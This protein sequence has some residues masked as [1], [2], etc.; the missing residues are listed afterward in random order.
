M[1]PAA[2]R[3]WPGD[4]TFGPRVPGQPDLTL[5]FENVMFGVIP[6]L[7]AILLTP[8]SLKQSFRDYGTG[9]VSPVL[10][11]EVLL[12]SGCFATEVAGSDQWTSS[13]SSASYAFLSSAMASAAPLCMLLVLFCGR[14]RGH[15]P[16]LPAVYAAPTALLDIIK[17]RSYILRDM[18]GIAA[19][20]LVSAILKLLYVLFGNVSSILQDK[21][22][23]LR[24]R[25][26]FAWAVS[27][28]RLGFSDLAQMENLPQLEST[29][30]TSVLFATFQLRWARVDKN[31][32]HPLLKVCME[33]LR[34]EFTLILTPRLLFFGFTFA[35][36]FI[37]RHVTWLVEESHAPPDEIG[38]MTAVTAMTFMGIG[39][40][41]GYYREL[42]S[43]VSTYTHGLLVSA[44]FEK[45]LQ[46]DQ[47][48]LEK[49]E[50][51]KLIKSELRAIGE[52]PR[53]LC[54][55]AIGLLELAFGM[56]LLWR[57]VGVWCCAVFI[58]GL[59]IAL[60]TTIM[61][62][63]NAGAN[64]GNQQTQHRIAATSHALAQL[65][66]IK[67]MGLGPS[68]SK[69][70]K[71]LHDADIKSSAF[72]RGLFAAA[73][74][75]ETM[76]ETVTPMLVLIGSISWLAH[77]PFHSPSQ[78]FTVMS[79]VALIT[80]TMIRMMKDIPRVASGIA[81][82]DRIDK[83]LLRRPDALSMEPLQADAT[84]I[85]HLRNWGSSVELK[86]ATLLH[87]TD[88]TPLLQ[89]V[90]IK[91]ASGGVT[92][93]YSSVAVGKSALA[94]VL[95]GEKRLDAGTITIPEGSAGYCDHTQW[96]FEGDIRQNII[97]QHQYIEEWYKRILWACNIGELA[98]EDRA[99]NREGWTQE[100]KCC[101][102]LAR[103]A[104]AKPSLLVMDDPCR[105][106]DNDTAVTVLDRLFGPGGALRLLGVTAVITTSNPLHLTVSDVAYELDG[107][108]NTQ[109]LQRHSHAPAQEPLSD[110]QADKPAAP[111][112]V[113][114]SRETAYDP[115]LYW[116]L[117]ESAGWIVTIF[118]LMFAIWTAASL[119]FSTVYLRLWLAAEPEQRT[120]FVGYSILT[121]VPIAFTAITVSILY[122]KFAPKIAR[123]LHQA[124]LTTAFTAGVTRLAQT[125]SDTLY[126][127]FIQDIPMFTM[128]LPGA[129]FEVAYL[130]IL[131]LCDMMIILSCNEYIINFATMVP[132]AVAFLQDHFLRL[133]DQL[134]TLVQ[135]GEAPVF[136]HFEHTTNGIIHI[137]A[138]RLER[139][140]QHGL[141]KHVDNSLQPHYAV[142]CIRRWLHLVIDVFIAAVAT[143]C[144][145]TALCLAKSR[146][147]T[148]IGLT[149][150][151]LV[152][153]GTVMGRLVDRWIDVQTSFAAL[154]R[155]RQF[156]EQPV[157]PFN[158]RSEIE[159]WQPIT[160]KLSMY[161]VTVG[162]EGS[163][164][165]ADNLRGV[166]LQV[167]DTTKVAILGSPSSGR[168]TLFLAILNMVDYAGTIYLDGNNV[169]H[170]A[171]ELLRSNVITLPRDGVEMPGSIRQ[172]LD[173]WAT[174]QRFFSDS[175]IHSVLGRIGATEMVRSRGGLSADFASAR[176]SR[177]EKQLIF[178]ARAILRKE[179]LDLHLVLV[180]DIT[181]DL[182]QDTADR[183][184]NIIETVFAD[185]SVITVTSRMGV[186]KN[187]HRIIQMSEGRVINMIDRPGPTLQPG[188]DK[189]YPDDDY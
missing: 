44:V 121:M 136:A 100:Q 67:V 98:D 178:L 3:L 27:T 7:I 188:E 142:S 181:H 23:L 122:M 156:T 74:I 110:Y 17:V 13:E 10:Y 168:S 82:F 169:E 89:D 36:P 62:C 164:A 14:V 83:F 37:L 118:S 26:C 150:L 184:H 129:F 18:R 154:N 69:Y 78:A 174:S 59:F 53:Q 173:P 15:W 103:A 151:N 128:T 24:G 2:S 47:D 4:D 123:K 68:V 102:Q 124:L 171:P 39:I 22:T 134:Q 104:Y 16:L 60:I 180:D 99:Q 106:L 141:E 8:Y 30:N 55:V 152:S 72:H 125:D 176:L 130:A 93:I 159:R 127:F 80:H 95:L 76:A 35:Q 109:L 144:V 177:A 117:F 161:S 170:L 34:R 187:M 165:G 87:P 92:M 167:P 32:R 135:K 85:G 185:C 119:R 107:N 28:L 163:P 40:S 61:T 162:F 45:T 19:T 138:M 105:L 6:A 29:L 91:F 52:F 84:E 33:S 11:L 166:S 42:C 38:K 158:K 90:S 9:T 137:R 186:L 148:A 64:T 63:S 143:F 88:L 126:N 183:I 182:D 131:A 70:L 5:L 1:S 43:R 101:V 133:Y 73:H 56:L 81:C 49:M 132:A 57:F 21:R 96:L 189:E 172:N 114:S 94:K 77:P 12:L 79:L 175:E 86:N 66:A 115:W 58:P 145:G 113:S 179:L 139:I 112:P 20:S 97:G 146:S 41:K 140:L 54:D 147:E 51:Q 48:V 157:T 50:A 31:S 120:M 25:S 75:I 149:L 160:G 46:L 155:V 116:F 71:E 153:F 65:T 111:A 108:G